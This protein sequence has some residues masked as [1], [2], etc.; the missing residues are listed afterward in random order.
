MVSGSMELWYSIRSNTVTS[1]YNVHRTKIEN[2]INEK[3]NN[4]VDDS[5][6]HQLW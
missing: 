5:T 3:V 6:D 4:N 1:G 2:K